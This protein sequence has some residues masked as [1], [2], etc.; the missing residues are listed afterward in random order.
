MKQKT[1]IQGKVNT[2]LHKVLAGL[3]KRCRKWGKM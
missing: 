3:M 2:V 1:Y